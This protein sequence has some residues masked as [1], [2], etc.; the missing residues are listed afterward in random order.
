MKSRKDQCTEQITLRFTP[1][2]FKTYEKL[3]RK[4]KK[5][6][7]VYMREV[8]LDAVILEKMFGMVIKDPLQQKKE[9]L[10]NQRNLF[11][12]KLDEG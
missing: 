1:K 3:A 7:A 10:D 12:T 4:I 2:D 5:P 6:L 8:L 9:I 11:S